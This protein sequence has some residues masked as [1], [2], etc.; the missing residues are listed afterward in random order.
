[1]V[2]VVYGH[3]QS[4]MANM[5]VHSKKD[6]RYKLGQGRIRGRLHHVNSQSATPVQERSMYKLPSNGA[7]SSEH[8]SLPSGEKAHKPT[9]LEPP[10]NHFLKLNVKKANRDNFHWLNWPI[11]PPFTTLITH[12]S[13][14]LIRSAC[15]LNTLDWYL[16]GSSLKYLL[17]CY[18]IV[19]FIPTK[20]KESYIY[21][22][23][24]SQGS[25][26]L[27]QN[28]G[29]YLAERILWRRMRELL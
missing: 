21:M 6:E 25:L 9:C 20:R 11:V 27:R 26:I 18:D 28:D 24:E 17:Y 7:S 1:M 12:C 15:M 23:Y 4:K 14:Y 5:K 10:S 13:R 22:F 29:K 16:G 3:S 8:W 2:T 19:I